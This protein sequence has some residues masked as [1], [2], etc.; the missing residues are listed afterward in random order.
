MS[1]DRNR[2]VPAQLWVRGVSLDSHFSFLISHFSKRN[3][4]STRRD[5][6]C[7]PRID[8]GGVDR[9]SVSSPNAALVFVKRYSS[10]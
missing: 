6:F 7:R 4:I 3:K 2:P 1:L 5:I 8:L 10:T 9:E